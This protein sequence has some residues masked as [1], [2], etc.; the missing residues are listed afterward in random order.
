[1]GL[2][3]ARPIVHGFL[4]GDARYKWRF[5]TQVHPLLRR[6]FLKLFLGGTFHLVELDWHRSQK[7]MKVFRCFVDVGGT[8]T[9]FFFSDR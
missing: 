2:S 1:M 4:L 6:R 3:S 8:E 7:S 9:L 5:A